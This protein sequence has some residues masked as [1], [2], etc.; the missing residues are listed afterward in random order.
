MP[1]DLPGTILIVVVGAIVLFVV[2]GI[3]HLLGPQPPQICGIDNP[4]PNL[5]SYHAPGPNE[6][7]GDVVSIPHANNV[8][9]SSMVELVPDLFTS[10]DMQCQSDNGMPWSDVVPGPFTRCRYFRL[11]GKSSPV[12]VQYRFVGRWQ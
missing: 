7:W 9:C 11:R 2:W 6:D 8:H 4:A 12:D 3:A 5:V 1:K 10:Y